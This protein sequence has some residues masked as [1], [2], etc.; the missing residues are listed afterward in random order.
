MCFAHTIH[1]RFLT[2]THPPMV[3]IPCTVV[4]VCVTILLQC[5]DRSQ[6]RSTVQPLL[7]SD[8]P[9]DKIACANLQSHGKWCSDSNLP[10]GRLSYE[11]L[12]LMPSISIKV[13][14]IPWSM[15]LSSM[16]HLTGRSAI[17]VVMVLPATSML[18]RCLSALFQA[19][20]TCCIIITNPLGSL[21]LPTKRFSGRPSKNLDH[22]P[23]GNIP[24]TTI[25]ERRVKQG[26]RPT[27]KSEPLERDKLGNL[28]GGN[29]QIMEFDEPTAPA[30]LQERRWS[31][32]CH[33]H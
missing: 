23:D 9:V 14:S 19:H 28:K 33:H 11:V 25:R 22:T 30:P 16:Y 15:S 6:Q 8:V 7:R 17:V 12:Q 21:G 29:V 10:P 24:I 32:W 5:R 3:F 31:V 4:A 18:R 13:S 1:D 20:N 2:L 26:S 27:W